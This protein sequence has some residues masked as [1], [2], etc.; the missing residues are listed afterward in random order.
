MRECMSSVIRPSLWEFYLTKGHLKEK[1]ERV[2]SRRKIV[3]TLSRKGNKNTSIPQLVQ[4]LPVQ[5]EGE[6]S[7][8]QT[9]HGCYDCI[10][11]RSSLWSHGQVLSYFVTFILWYFSAPLSDMTCWG[12]L[13]FQDASL[14]QSRLMDKTS[15]LAGGFTD[16]PMN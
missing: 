5:R 6:I 9:F 13:Y 3:P 16:R 15:H 8:S 14:N 1:T 12:C 4:R 11:D 7:A 10:S 2:H